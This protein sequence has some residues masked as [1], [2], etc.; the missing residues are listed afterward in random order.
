VQH[1]ITGVVDNF[2]DTCIHVQKAAFFLRRKRSRS[3]SLS[4]S[5]FGGRD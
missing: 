1:R 2:I 3:L 5:L 4:L